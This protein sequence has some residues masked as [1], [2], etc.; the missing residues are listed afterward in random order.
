MNDFYKEIIAEIHIKF[1]SMDK[2]KQK[3]L[4]KAPAFML[5]DA[6]YA[7]HIRDRRGVV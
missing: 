4:N 3:T 2:E 6:E 7:L 1:N 5:S